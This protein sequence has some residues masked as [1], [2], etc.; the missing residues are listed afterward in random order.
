MGVG[1]AE[2]FDFVDFRNAV[3]VYLFEV[4][5]PKSLA[6]FQPSFSATF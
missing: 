6:E 3:G 5:P 2:S 4:I 1:K